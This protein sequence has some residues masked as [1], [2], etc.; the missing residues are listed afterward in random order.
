MKET[1]N[2][3]YYVRAILFAAILLIFDQITKYLAV[4]HLKGKNPAILIQNVFELQ[5]LEN[6]GAAFSMLEGKNWFFIPLTIAFLLVIAFL[7]LRI[8]KTKKYFWLRA[9][10]ILFC[11]GALGNFIDRVRQG[12]VVDFFYFSLINF[13]IFY[14]ADIYIV[15]GTILL[16]LL[17]FFYYKEEDLDG[18][19]KRKQ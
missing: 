8:P 6:H 1:S 3:K 19:F 12:Y 16:I 2:I 17:I 15:V 4:I 10:A 13:P 5:Y 11:A 7:Y 18:I 14:V 9:V